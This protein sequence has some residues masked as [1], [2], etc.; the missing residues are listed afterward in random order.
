MGGESGAV[1]PDVVRGAGEL[2][3]RPDKGRAVEEGAFHAGMYSPPF[4]SKIAPVTSD[5]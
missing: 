4:T 3:R 5:V 1:G 2:H